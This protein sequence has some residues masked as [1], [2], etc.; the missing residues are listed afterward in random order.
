[1]ATN[2]PPQQPH[3]NRRGLYC[4]GPNPGIHLSKLIEIVQ[5]PDF[6]TGGLI[7][8]VRGSSITL[9][10]AVDRSIAR[11]CGDREFGKDREA[12]IV[13]EIPYQVNKPP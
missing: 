13:T 6:P 8:A 1:M 2:I 10:P 11:P 9:Q 4:A 3:G 5:G 12:I 7:S